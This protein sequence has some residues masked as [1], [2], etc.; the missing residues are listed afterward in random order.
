MQPFKKL[1]SPSTEIGC[2]SKIIVS[3]LMLMII[4]LKLKTI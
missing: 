4:F 2:H 3:I 1:D